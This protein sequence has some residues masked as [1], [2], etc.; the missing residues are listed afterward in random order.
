MKILYAIQG[1]GNGHISRSS[2]IIPYFKKYGEVD[3]LIS[4]IQSDLT[5]PF[6]VTYKYQGL[7]FVFGKKGGIDLVNTYLKNHIKRF[8][9]EVKSLPIEQYDLIINDFEPISAWAA[10]LKN[11]PCVA[12]SN[13]CALKSFSTKRKLNEDVV[14]KFILNN[15]APSSAEYGF[16]YKP[17]APHIF[18]PIIRREVRE[19]LVANKGHYTVY[20]PAYSKKQIVKVL[21]LMKDQKWEVFLKGLEEEELYGQFKFLPIRNDSFLDS[22]AN[23]EG[24][25]TAAGFGTTSEA[26]YL[27][28]KLLVIPQK[29]QYE[30]Y[31]NSLA[32]DELG[33]T[34]LK[35]FKKKHITSLK[36]WI[37]NGKSV[38]V[39]YPDQTNEIVETIV[40]NEYHNKDNYLNYLTSIQYDIAH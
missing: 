14:G 17:H 8:M 9:K 12:L 7:S 20:L 18:K 2:E 16:N 37:D 22:L 5:L 32:L 15:Y 29:Q 23:C 28:K 36:N 24:I 33:V 39:E 6:D 4:G 26:L 21:S 19:L 30:Q 11:K 1:T 10:N 38:Q 3:I 34:V 25:I 31:L 40:N 27:N 35:S 13:Q